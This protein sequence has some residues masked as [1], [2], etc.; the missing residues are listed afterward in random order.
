MKKTI[1]PFLAAVLLFL[2]GS[3]MDLKAQCVSGCNTNTYVN[4]VDP[5]T[6]E[7]DNMV[8]V[9]H[10][11]MAKEYDGTLKVWGQGVT[12]TSG[13]A[14]TPIV[15]NPANFGTGANQLSGT[16][17][18]FAGGSNVNTQQ[19]AVLT[20]NGLYIWGNAGVLVPSIG[21]ISNNLLCI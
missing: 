9:F 21:N 20:S 15:V 10:S 13:N 6:I 7:Y 16:I 17:L 2:A 19:F 4:S 11:S 12:Q 8:G 5:K 3:S 18:K 1:Y 14:L